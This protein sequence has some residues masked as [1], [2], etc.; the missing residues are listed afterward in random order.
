M[1]DSQERPITPEGQKARRPETRN[2]EP[3][4]FLVKLDIPSLLVNDSGYDIH[5]IND[6]HDIHDKSQPTSLLCDV[7]LLCWFSQQDPSGM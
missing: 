4:T 7:G 5:D 1:S 2:P 6:I 3:K